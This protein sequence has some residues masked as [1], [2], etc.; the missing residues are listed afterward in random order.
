MPIDPAWLWRVRL[1]TA[2]CVF[3]TAGWVSFWFLG[4]Y[5]KI[6]PLPRLIPTTAPYLLIVIGLFTNPPN[7]A[8]LALAAGA[9]LASLPVMLFGLGVFFEGDISARILAFVYLVSHVVLGGS[10]LKSFSKMRPK[11][12]DWLYFLTASVAA[13]IV[14]WGFIGAALF[15]GLQ[16]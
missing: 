1:A 10:A 6:D 2:L 7:R 9:L 16:P 11:L 3:A 12:R 14:F 4:T 5:T 8:A 15:Y 13:A